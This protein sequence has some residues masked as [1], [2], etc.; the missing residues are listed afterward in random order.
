MFTFTIKLKQDVLTVFTYIPFILIGYVS[1]KKWIKSRKENESEEQDISVNFHFH[2]QVFISCLLHSLSF[3]LPPHAM[4][5]PDHQDGLKGFETSVTCFLQAYLNVM[6]FEA[7]NYPNFKFHF[8]H[9]LFTNYK[10][11]CCYQKAKDF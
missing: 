8:N 7:T 3:T 4:S 5:Q 1:I 6:S 9:R 11:R 10:S 2:I